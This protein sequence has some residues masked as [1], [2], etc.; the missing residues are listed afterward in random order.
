LVSASP[1]V[2]VEAAGKTWGFEPADIAAATPALQGVHVLP[3]MDG[4]V[5]YAADKL[6]AGR[7][8]FGNARWL[9][10]FGDNVFDVDMLTTAEMGVAIRPKPRLASELAALGLRQLEPWL[11]ASHPAVR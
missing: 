2:I 9:A 3:R 5:P 4:P 7:A 1:R 8:L 11:T 6:S 10:A